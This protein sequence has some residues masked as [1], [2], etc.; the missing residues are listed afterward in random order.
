M[1]TILTSVE[2][3]EQAQQMAHT[4]L[5]QRLAACIQQTS[6]TSIYRWH[7]DIEQCEEFYLLIKTRVELKDVVIHWL[8]K[9]HPYD[10]PEIIV[11][12]AQASTAYHAW[13]HSETNKA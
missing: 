5:Q 8:Q 4:L 13:L 3:A 10:T 11:L 2:H 6:G 9:H 7:G 12:E 1:I